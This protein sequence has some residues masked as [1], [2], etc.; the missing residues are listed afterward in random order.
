[1]HTHY[2]VSFSLKKIFTYK[3][4]PRSLDVYWA[5][6]VNFFSFFRTQGVAV[7]YPLNIIFVIL[8][9][10][11]YLKKKSLS[12]GAAVEVLRLTVN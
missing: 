11:F 12:I 6:Y 2:P 9:S 4:I 1:M 8:F 7:N 10:N 3:D 5:I